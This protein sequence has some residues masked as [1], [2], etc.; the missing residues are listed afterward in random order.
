MH[1]RQNSDGVLK[2]RKLQKFVQKALVDSEIT[3]DESQVKETLE[4]KVRN[5]LYHRISHLI[6]NEFLMIFFACAD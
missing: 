3:L 4:Q 2:L 5:S 6:G 1:V